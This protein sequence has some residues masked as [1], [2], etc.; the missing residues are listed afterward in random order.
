MPGAF[1][2][3]FLMEKE[4]KE[5]V[6][7]NYEKIG[8]YLWAMTAFFSVIYYVVDMKVDI[9]KLQVEIEHLKEKEK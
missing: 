3:A 6:K 8:I 9:G 2:G 5:K 1:T 7:T 4:N